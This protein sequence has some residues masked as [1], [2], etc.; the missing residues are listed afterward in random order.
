GAGAH[1]PDQ[2]ARAAAAVVTA[3]PLLVATVLLAVI[4]AWGAGR[5]SAAEGLAVGPWPRVLDASSWTVGLTC[6][7]VLF[8]VGVPVAALGWSLRV[9]MDPVK[10]LDE[11]G[12][13]VQGALFVALLAAA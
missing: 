1:A 5:T 2:P 12:P 6:L 3:A 10:L 7:L 4:A 9:P 11:F 8:N 13:Q